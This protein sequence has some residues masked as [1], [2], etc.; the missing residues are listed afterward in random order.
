MHLQY[1]HLRELVQHL[2][3]LLLF[4]LPTYRVSVMLEPRH[5]EPFGGAHR[6]AEGEAL[7]KF[8]T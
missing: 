7:A 4:T 5:G 6:G 8:Y 1:A 2:V 3:T